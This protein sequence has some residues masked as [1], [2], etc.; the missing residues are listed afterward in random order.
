MDDT[1]KNANRFNWILHHGTILLH[2]GKDGKRGIILG[3]GSV[4]HVIEQIDNAMGDIS[5]SRPNDTKMLEH[6]MRYWDSQNV[7]GQLFG[8]GRYHDNPTGSF[9][10]AIMH[11]MKKSVR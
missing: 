2:D 7:G 9:R 11:D 10:D 1:E 6:V 8:D 4:E 3:D 5:S